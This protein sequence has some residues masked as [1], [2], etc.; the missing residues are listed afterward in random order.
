MADNTVDITVKIN[1]VD[2]QIKSINDLKGAIKDLENEVENAEL[3]SEQFSNAKKELDKLTESLE[4]F[5]KSAKDTGDLRKQFEVLED[6]LFQLAGAGKQ[7]T[8]EFKKLTIEAAN[9]NK[10]ID[11]V[12]QSLSGGGAERAEAGFAKFG[13]SLKK[14]DFKGVAQG[15]KMMGT[16]LA[17]TGVMLIVQAVG[18][19]VENFEELSQGSGLLA[20]ALRFVGDIIG[21]IVDAFTFLTDKIGLTNSALEKQGEVAEENAKKVTEALAEQTAEYD[22]QIAVAKANGQNTVELEIKK[23]QAILATNKIIAEQSLALINARIKAGEELTEDEIKRAK[24][25]VNNIKNATAQIEII[26]AT[27]SKRI[28]DENKK[29]AEQQAEL[30]KKRLEDEK[31][32]RDEIAAYNR[33]AVAENQKI[34]NDEALAKANLRLARNQEDID[35]KINLLKVQ[36]D[37]ELQNA[38]L[39][40]SARKLI[41]QKYINDVEALKKV[42]RDKELKDIEDNNKKI[43]DLDNKNLLAGAELSA[44]QNQNDLD[45]QLA[46]LETKKQLEL[47]NTELTENERLLIKE[48]YAGLEKQAQFKSIQDALKIA[49]QGTQSLQNLSDIYFTF[50]KRNLQKGSAEEEKAA[51]QQFKINKALQLTGAIIDGAKAITSSLAQ[52]PVAIGP[53]PNPAG[54]AS[55]ALAITSSVA[56]IAKIAATKYEGGASGGGG[57]SIS[58]PSPSIPSAPTVSTPTNNIS[59][60]QFDAQGNTITPQA[61]QPT[62]TVKAQVVESDMTDTQ[63]TVTKYKAQ[64]TF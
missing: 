11:D 9:L 4:D 38:E 2:K 50:K 61:Q 3:G 17:A 7:N 29:R 46:L 55:L 44:L 60:T 8:A 64:S 43:N 63:N 62:I 37:I 6:Q 57:G 34:D 36:K 48:K 32:L 22:R 59:G 53:I 10:Q 49:E 25:A 15:A 30:N 13:D 40:A 24:E 54:I 39:T 52:A 12:N 28:D 20:K 47:E 56:S 33:A 35:A 1:G 21:S 14:L 27:E 45:A 58:A 31:K 5:S 41:E 42:A 19:L 26:R 16:A 18:Y 23:Q 51:R